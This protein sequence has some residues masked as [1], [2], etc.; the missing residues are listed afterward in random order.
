M[1][2][3]VNPDNEVIIDEI[4]DYAT[5][6]QVRDMLQEYMRRL[7]VEQ[8]KEPLKF[9]IKEITE[10]PFVITPK[11]GADAEEKEAANEE[12]TQEAVEE[13]AA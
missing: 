13:T 2:K 1:S 6:N 7:I 9:L 12:K 4:C 3:V 10:N 8:P 11:D 5:Q